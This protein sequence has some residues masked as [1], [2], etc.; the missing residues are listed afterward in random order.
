MARANGTSATEQAPLTRTVVAR[1]RLFP[2][3]WNV[4]EMTVEMF[5]KEKRSISRYGFVDPLL[6]RPH[7]W[8]K[9]CYQIIDG[10]HRF[11]GGSELGMVD[12]PVDIID[13]D[14]ETAQELSIVLNETRGVANQGKLAALV[15]SL[16]EK[17][18]PDQLQK[19]LPFTRR[20]FE[21]MV[22]DEQKL[23]FESLKE[24]SK[25][26]GRENTGWVE[27]VFRMPADS[28]VVIDDALKRIMAAERIE[29]EWRALEFMAA[30]SLA[31]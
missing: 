8:E 10:E 20:R 22:S 27:R 6:V 24:R 12:F 4:N 21:E 15:R 11:R 29:D 26:L 25:A 1:E 5:Q 13:V 9:D 23:D 3:P 28:A 17:R 14:D 16:A 30:D 2:N 7:P 19:V 31:S 18:D